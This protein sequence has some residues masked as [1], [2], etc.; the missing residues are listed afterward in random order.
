MAK[1][2]RIEVIG[3][4]G[5]RWVD[6]DYTR[7]TDAR[8]KAVREIGK[9]KEAVIHA[10][11]GPTYG[12]YKNTVERVFFD[13]YVNDYA[14]QQYGNSKRKSRRYRVSPKTGRLLDFSREWKYI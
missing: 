7:I 1:V 13:D 10:Y 12:G 5:N 9:T 2:Y 11:E 6:T 8:K 14:V 3:D 4:H